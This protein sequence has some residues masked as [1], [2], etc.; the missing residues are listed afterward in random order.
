MTSGKPKDVL[1]KHE[2]MAIGDLVRI[3]RLT[4]LQEDYYNLK[5]GTVARVSRS[6]ADPGAIVAMEYSSY[7]VSLVTDGGREICLPI[8][9]VS[10]LSALEALALQAA[11]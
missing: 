8:W 2:S 3:S 11:E 6:W 7:I 4:K 10:K 1:G 9:S 5:V